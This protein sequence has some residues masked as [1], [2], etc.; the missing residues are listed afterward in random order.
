MPPVAPLPIAGGRLHGAITFTL[1][2]E[3][4][5]HH[6][7]TSLATQSAD[8]T[9]Q[10]AQV[11]HPERAPTSCGHH[12]RV[13]LNRI[14]PA[15]RQRMLHALIIKEEHPILRPVPSNAH[16]QKPATMP[17]MKRMGHP[18]SPLPSIG[19]RST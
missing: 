14:G 18:D 6:P 17:R 5:L 3:L 12:E 2:A 9:G 19:I 4:A 8:Q 7:R 13:R 1:K 10:C 16:Q 11:G 15:H